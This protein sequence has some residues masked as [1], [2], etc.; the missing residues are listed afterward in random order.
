MNDEPTAA[1]SAEQEPN[2][3]R[4]AQVAI[5]QLQ[6][7]AEQQQQQIEKA[8]KAARWRKIQ[9]RVLGVVTA[10]LLI[11]CSLGIAQFFHV[12]NVANQVQRGAIAQCESGNATR[13]NEIQV[14]DDILN[15]F[16]VGK[17]NPDTI[18]FVMDKEAFVA[19]ELAPRN[20]Q[21]TFQS[22]S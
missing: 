10:V 4:A 20:C 14:W 12:R 15:A 3:M 2:F 5:R 9:V 19:K 7:Q 11:A 16:L 18:K 8:Q 22:G 13:A 1:P 17:P 21:Q 6:D